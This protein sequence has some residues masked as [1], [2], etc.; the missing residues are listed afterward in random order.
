MSFLQEMLVAAQKVLD[1]VKLSNK[2]LPAPKDHTSYLGEEAESMRWFLLPNE[3][4]Q[5]LSGQATPIVVPPFQPRRYPKEH[6]SESVRDSMLSLSGSK[7]LS[8]QK[9]QQLGNGKS[10]DVTGKTESSREHRL[11]RELSQ[12]VRGAEEVVRFHCPPKSIYK[13]T[14]EVHLV[15]IN[16]Q[17]G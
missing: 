12:D 5:L 4:H 11:N 17:R 1:E 6:C 3:A 14:T 9:S 16:L 10:D 7:T 15:I 2:P 8:L 13:P